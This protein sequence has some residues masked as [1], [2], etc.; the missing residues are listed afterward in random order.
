MVVPVFLWR[1]PLWAGCISWAAPSVAR[2]LIN[3][4]FF[5][6]ACSIAAWLGSAW[7][8]RHLALVPS[9]A[10]VALSFHLCLAFF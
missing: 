7:F 8:G 5:G 1:G 6:S 9:L 10:G 2:V 4:A 3:L